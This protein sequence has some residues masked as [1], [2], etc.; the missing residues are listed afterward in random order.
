MVRLVLYREANIDY[1]NDELR[2]KSVKWRCTKR[3]ATH[4]QAQKMRIKH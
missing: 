3:W 2:E 1:E 4:V